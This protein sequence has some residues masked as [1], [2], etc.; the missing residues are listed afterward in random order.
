M[1]PIAAI[2]GSAACARRRQLADQQLALDLQPDEQEEDRHQAV[3]DPVQQRLFEPER[4][5]A[6]TDVRLE[7]V[8]VEA[9]GG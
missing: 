5:H 2:T 3:V 4:R 1:P 9:A 7:H 8:L 6:E